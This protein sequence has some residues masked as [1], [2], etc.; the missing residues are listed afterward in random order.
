MKKRKK[1]NDGG[2][3]MDKRDR[4]MSDPAYR[5]QLEREQALE[6]SAPEAMLVGPGKVTSGLTRFLRP[7]AR[8]PGVTPE[9]GSKLPEAILRKHTD[10]Y[11]SL[12]GG[13]LSKD[14]VSSLA[15]QATDAEVRQAKNQAKILRGTVKERRARKVAEITDD[16]AKS[17]VRPVGVEYLTN[18]KEEKMK[19]GGAV[20]SAASRGDGIAQRGKTRG[21]M[22]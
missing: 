8:P 13:K 10:Y 1:F 14:S 22:C 7:G 17:V 4:D 11:R 5:K 2:S 21:K 6:T 20:K 12:A 15:K 3:V 19:K 9:I 16:V 18:R